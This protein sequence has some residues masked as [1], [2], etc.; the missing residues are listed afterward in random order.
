MKEDAAPRPDEAILA[1]MHSKDPVRVQAAIKDLKERM[2]KREW[3][4]IPPLDVAILEP[5]GPD[6]PEEIQLDF[7]KVI[8]RYRAFRPELSNKEKIALSVAVVLRYGG[9]TRVTYDVALDLKISPDPVEA[10]DLAMTEIVHQGLL[11]P[12]NI[13]GA[14]YLVSC[15][16][17]GKAEVRRATLQALR[18]WPKEKPYMDVK[19]YI[20]PQL[21]SDEVEF[22]NGESRGS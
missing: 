4:K 9:K 12:R 20:T 11:S 13:K 17:D 16:L 22:L 7:L 19:K 6:I 8:R 2:N 18:Q 1:D 15:L 14:Q 3:I 21:E 5:L 10:V